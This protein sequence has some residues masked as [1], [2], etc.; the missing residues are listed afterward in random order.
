MPIPKVGKGMA[1]GPVV[2]IF[3]VVLSQIS[4]YTPIIFTNIGLLL[5]IVMSLYFV[6]IMSAVWDFDRQCSGPIQS[7]NKTNRKFDICRI[8]LDSW[9]NSEKCKILE[10]SNVI[11]TWLLAYI[12]FN[13][14][15]TLYYL[16]RSRCTWRWC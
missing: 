4:I 7:D 12:G 15:G 6:N 2:K 11:L 10:G 14:R 13:R 3:H 16:S 9:P 5:C 1:V 8:F